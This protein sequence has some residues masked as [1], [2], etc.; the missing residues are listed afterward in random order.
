MITVMLCCI[1]CIS[2]Q[3]FIALCNIQYPS[4]LRLQQKIGHE[5]KLILLYNHDVYDD[6]VKMGIVVIIDYQFV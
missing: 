5:R 2:D 4:D 6:N 3:C 1:Q